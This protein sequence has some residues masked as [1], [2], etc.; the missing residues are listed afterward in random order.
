MNRVD[1]ALW[2][3]H[4]PLDLIT[5]IP[6]AQAILWSVNIAMYEAEL[7]LWQ[8]MIPL[9]TTCFTAQHCMYVHYTLVSGKW[10]SITTCAGIA[11]GGGKRQRQ[12]SRTAFVP[13]DKDGEFARRLPVFHKQSRNDDALAG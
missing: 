11:N 6:F 9:C 12:A 8:Y 13:E 4:V 2:H 1:H 5:G 3:Q 7:C 10:L